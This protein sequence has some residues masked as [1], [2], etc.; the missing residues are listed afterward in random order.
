VCSAEV[1][2]ESVSLFCR[3]LRGISKF[4]LQKVARN[5]SVCSAEGCEESV[6]LFSRMFGGI[7]KFVLQKFERN[8]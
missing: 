7:S 4:V 6:S 8:L 1:W 3:R 2:G 5:Q